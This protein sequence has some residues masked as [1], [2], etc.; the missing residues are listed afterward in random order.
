M[1]LLKKYRFAVFSLA[2]LMALFC[3]NASQGVVALQVT[4]FSVKEMLMI[5]PPI[6]ILLGL[7][8]VW[9]PRETMVRFMGTDSGVK[10]VLLAFILGSAAAGPLYGAFPIAAVLMKKGTSY[11]NV[12]I[13]LGAWS[14]TK[15]PLLLFEM[16]SMGAP[17]MLVR[18]LVNIPG[19]LF[20]AWI[21]DFFIADDE[22]QRL[23]LNA[24][25]LTS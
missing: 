12:L 2:V 17:F 5:V 1:A 7:L 25:H 6:F 20:I 11:R 18:L 9:V 8:D 14:T 22:R 23:Y 10:G 19:I 13:F 15:I 24:E 4:A 3:F 16:T 21:V